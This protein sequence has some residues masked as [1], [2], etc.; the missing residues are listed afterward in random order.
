MSKFFN[1]FFKTTAVVA[2][3]LSTVIMSAVTFYNRT[4]PSNFYVKE[5][6]DF[7]LS[8]ASAITGGKAI[9]YEKTS[10]ANKT[11]GTSEIVELKLLNFIPI[12]QTH[13]KVINDPTITP[14]GT[15]FGIKLFTKGVIVIDIT[16]VQTDSGIACPA[17]L[18]GILKGD[19]VLTINNIEVSSNE[20][21]ADIIEL[22]NGE[23][24]SV[25]LKRDNQTIKTMLKPAISNVDGK[26]KGG[27]WV[28]DSSA[29]I[30]TITYYLK[31]DLRFAGLGHGICDIDT[32]KIMPLNT[33]E[34][35]EVSINS[36]LKG[37]AGTP[38]ELR[39]SFIS[40]ECV[41]KLVLNN[42]SG[43]FGTLSKSPNNFESVPIRL[44]QDIQ[45]GPAKIIC[46]LDETGPKEY[47]INIDKIDLNPKTMTKNMVITVTD[48]TLLSK[49]GGIV[50]GMSGS[51][52]LQNG[53]LVGAVTHVFVNNPT[54]G[55]GIF[56]E[57]MVNFTEMLANSK[58]K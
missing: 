8:Q 18:A 13:I 6:S 41:G 51:P 5:G 46:T 47:A 19:I 2:L 21:V 4:M 58:S 22:S 44:K 35:C 26:Y 15:P 45:K 36:V 20:E 31:D 30:G 7:V 34:V 43:I 56:A 33:G 1:K 29:G 55:Y 14:G 3:A 24:L 32:G 12:K 28:R 37:K 53:S 48:S 54:K 42:E 27:L 11:K 10:F 23:N 9:N 25:T 50:Q 52:I 16:N 57:N 49:T 40:D 39:G 17:K 38:G